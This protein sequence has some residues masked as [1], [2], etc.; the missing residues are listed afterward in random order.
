MRS[1]L[2]LAVASVALG[3]CRTLQPGTAIADLGLTADWPQRKLILQQLRQYE[4]SGRVAIAANGQGLNAQF[5]WRQAADSAELTLRGPLGAGGLMVRTDAG[6]IELKTTDGRKL[7]GDA[8]RQE[9]ERSI[10]APLPI[11]ALGYWL[12]GTTQPEASASETLAA[13]IAGQPAQLAA[14]EQQGWRVE[15]QPHTGAPQRMTLTSGTARVRLVI[16][17]WKWPR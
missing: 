13:A 3:A 11:A 8:A 4:C 12:L 15:F 17:K 7:D 10:G 16:E 6:Q 5:V 9:L 2:L 1:T 14:L